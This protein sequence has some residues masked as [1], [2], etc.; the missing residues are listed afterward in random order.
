MKLL[1]PFFTTSVCLL[2][3]S[4]FILGITKAH[5]QQV[6]FNELFN[7]G[8]NDEW[9][10]LLV[11][12]DSL[13]M[14]GWDIRDF[15]SGGAAQLPLDLTTSSLWQNLRAGT[16]IVVARPEN[17]T[18]QE[19]VD[20][21][22]YSLLIKTNNASYFT[23]N[24]F[25]FAG[26]SDAIQIRTASDQHVM[27]VSWGTANAS[28]IPS[29][30]V[31]FSGTS[32][33]NTS[34]SFNEDSL[35][36]LTS[37]SN[38]TINN[39]TATI[40]AG[41]TPVNTAWINSFRLRADGSGT[42][43]IFPD[44]L[45][46]GTTGNI[47]L[48]YRRDTQFTVTDLRIIVPP[49]FGWSHL[50]A[51]ITFT[52]MTAA[53]SVA[54]DTIYLNG[55]VL[56]LDST[57]ITIQ[58]IT[59]TDTTGY[60]PFHVQSRVNAY[61]N[62]SPTPRIVVFGLP[63]PIAEMKANDSLGVPLRM[64]GLITVRGI[65][66]VAN[67]FGGPSYF[68]D[69]SGGM[70]LFGS[71][72]STIVNIGDEV[73]VSG[74][75]QPFSGLFEIVNPRLHSIVS[76]GNAVTP[77]LVTASQIA[78][79]GANGVELYEGLLVRINAA[80]VT[81]TG[82]W[83][84]NANYPLN[85]PSG[86]TE[87]RIDNNTNLVGA[88]I[89]AGVFDAIGVVGQFRTTPPFIGG[90]QFMPR[91]SSDILSTGPII[92]SFPRETGILPTS[93]TVFWQT[94]NNGTTRARY[95]LTPGFELGVVG[96][97]SMSTNHTVL[98]G[99]LT[100]ATIYYIQ[101]FSVAG[102]DTSYASTLIASTASPASAT[103]QVNVYFNKSV[104]TTLAW[105][106]PANGNENF[107][108]RLLPRLNNAR[109]SIDVA[110]YSLSGT[111][112]SNI[113]TALV[114]AR[115]RG[116]RVRAICEFDNRANAGFSFL[117]ANSIPLINDAF[118]PVNAGVGLMH[119]KFLVVDGRGG[120]PES[121]WVVMGSW[122][123]T[124][125]GTNSD[126]QNVVELQDPAIANAYTLEFNEMWGSSTE[127]PNSSNSRFGA[128][129]TDNTPHRFMIG[130]KNIESYFSPSD[131]VTSKIVSAINGAEHSVGFQLLT[132]TRSEIASA[133]V[134]KKNAG[135]KVRGDLDNG[136]DTGS[137]YDYLIANNVDVR[138]KTGAG[139][140]HHKYGIVDAENPYWNSI[141]ITGSHNWSSA[142]ENSNN[143][144]TLVIR[145]GNITN[146][147]LQEFAA[148]YVQFGGTDPIVV[149]VD[150]TS[151]TVPLSFSLDQNY[152]NPFNPS[153]TVRF[154][155]P[156]LQGNHQAVTLK[157][158]DVLGREVTVL[159]NEPLKAGSYKVQF[160]A[161]NFASGVYFYRLQT[162]SLTNTKKFILMK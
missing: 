58:N 49:T 88:P 28:S 73:I 103:G 138:L 96:N 60:Y 122:N 154:T 148:R 2:F 75:V 85:D 38:W 146:Q 43:R 89:P 136:T 19:D 81:G 123:P 78:N 70:A 15:S 119:N 95:G 32:T 51:D 141:T 7:S 42:A 61:A 140:L 161:V 105:F 108:N 77:L 50:A 151:S 52:N 132:L 34:I 99:G 97:D 157:V 113:A 1:K 17:T 55:I 30:K 104:N 84:A 147:F 71:S 24:P 150:E 114:N 65:V 64:N 86:T 63:L 134:A 131:R 67:E 101:A 31:H 130:G 82:V 94:V 162:G 12:Q 160:T 45:N 155:I 83:T 92:A 23:G 124:D 139:L 9:I 158:Y 128:R 6:I 21:S 143:E 27:G 100:P 22:D 142:A 33:S 109:R 137:Q 47:R 54:G 13:D 106:Q 90:Y 14:R 111:V 10:E 79:D 102:G 76:T 36:E 8:G 116:V 26:A 149:G 16:L 93:L 39:S 41:N 135:K 20:P 48:T 98:L 18:L 11:I 59:A 80:T 35:P 117:S 129:K 62:V 127:V 66:T 126:Y 144:N 29:P 57:V 72:F 3:L 69:N 152:P 5:S 145:D 56:S 153:T 25:V 112:G 110:L 40:G 91:F 120:A 4:A 115:N 46:G 68:Q 53:K 133:L 107:Y 125:S 118:D 37:T 44:T 74:V 156:D 159:I 121:V 87:I